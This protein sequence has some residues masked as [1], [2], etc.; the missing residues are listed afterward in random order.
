M[1]LSHRKCQP[2]IWPLTT[3]PCPRRLSALRC[4][5]LKQTGPR[6]VLITRSHSSICAVFQWRT[7]WRTCYF[8]P[9]HMKTSNVC[10]VIMLKPITGLEGFWTLYFGWI[11]ILGNIFGHIRLRQ[12][13]DRK[14]PA[15]RISRQVLLNFFKRILVI[16]SIAFLLWIFLPS[17]HLHQSCNI[18]VGY[19]YLRSLTQPEHGK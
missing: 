4:R 11:L 10:S 3:P 9:W 18:K 5:N 7:R 2:T 8:K 6:R 13:A 15:G 14:Y 19:C 12:S 16:Q 1:G 17:F